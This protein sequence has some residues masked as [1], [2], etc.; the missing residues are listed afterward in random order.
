GK[1]FKVSYSLSG[2]FLDQCEMW[3]KSL[4]EKFKRMADSGCVEFLCETYYH[5]LASL[6]E[7]KTEFV[8]QVKQHQQAMKDYLGQKP[9]VFRN[10]EL[11]YHNDIAAE[12]EKLGFDAI[13]TE[14]IERILEGWK[15][16]NFLYRRHKG[17]I[18]VLLRNYQLSDDMGYRFSARWWKEYPLT[19]DKYASWLAATPGDSINIFIDYETFGEHHWEDTGIFWFL[20]ALPQEILKW[21]RLEFSTPSEVVDRYKPVGEINVPYYETVS[22]ADMERDASA[23]IGNHMQ[24]VVF[25]SMKEIG[26]L[27][28]ESKNEEFIRIWRYLQTGD[29]FYYMCTKC[30]ADGDVHKYFSHHGNPYDA[31]VNYLAVLL[32]LKERILRYN[33]E[34][35]KSSLE[36]PAKADYTPAPAKNKMITSTPK[37]STIIPGRR[38][39]PEDKYAPG[40]WKPKTDNSEIISASKTSGNS[41]ITRARKITPEEKYKPK[42]DL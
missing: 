22:W 29:H 18:K 21:E 25:H 3:D 6:Y 15:S 20:G 39:T 7:D 2:T 23:W 31:G 40:L 8:E 17:D 38:I 11:L 27:A 32:D 37:E 5:S 42:T 16:P 19:A 34:K 10:T 14:G 1:K 4:L 41:Q 36:Q 33:Y 12:V 9:R 30:L 13:M 35:Q 28:L 24:Q 26:K